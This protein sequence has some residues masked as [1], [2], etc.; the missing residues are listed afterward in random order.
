MTNTNSSAACWIGTVAP[1]D[2]SVLLWTVSRPHAG[3]TGRQTLQTKLVLGSAWG[4]LQQSL[5]EAIP[6]VARIISAFPALDRTEVWAAALPAQRVDQGVSLEAGT[7]EAVLGKGAFFCEEYLTPELA[8]SSLET[9]MSATGP[10]QMAEEESEV[11]CSGP[12]T[13]R[14]VGGQRVRPNHT[15]SAQADGSGSADDLEASVANASG[16]PCRSAAARG[17]AKR[18]GILQEVDSASDLA[19]RLPSRAGA[20]QSKGSK[21]GVLKKAGA[22]QRKG[23]KRL[24]PKG[25]ARAE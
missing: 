23:R 6:V 1:E 13:W 19:G 14:P 8:A 20:G 10:Q 11:Y 21:R 18:R 25:G 17:E 24:G 7:A 15:S 4:Q 2:P 5:A 12:A 3:V 16:Q 22:G 9:Q